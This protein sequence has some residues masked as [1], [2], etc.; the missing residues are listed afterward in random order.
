M[1]EN[2]YRGCLRLINSTLKQ[3]LLSSAI[4]STPQNRFI[5]VRGINYFHLG[6]TR[7]H[8]R[9]SDFTNPAFIQAFLHL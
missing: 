1:E 3:P 2:I 7:A 5:Q 9:H 6:S 4:F 8:H